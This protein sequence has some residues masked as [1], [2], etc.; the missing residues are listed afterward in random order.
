MASCRKWRCFSCFFP[1]PHPA[2]EASPTPAQEVDMQQL[3]SLIDRR[4]CELTDLIL[5]GP[6]NNPKLPDFI[7]RR[8]LEMLI[9][10]TFTTII[11][12]LLSPRCQNGL[13]L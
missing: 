12:I 5:D 11:T 3:S 10:M 2:S 7:E 13:K 6:F 9:S 4:A 1:S 8:I